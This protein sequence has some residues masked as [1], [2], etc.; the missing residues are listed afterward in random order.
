MPAPP[1]KAGETSPFVRHDVE[2]AGVKL[3]HLDTLTL[4]KTA[5]HLIHSQLRTQRIPCDRIRQ[6][7]D[8]GVL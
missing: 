1:S 2:P 7:P 8:A 3:T 6:V 4:I 5:S